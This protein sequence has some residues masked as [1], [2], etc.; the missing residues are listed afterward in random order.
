MLYVGID[1]GTSAVKLVLMNEIGQVLSSVSE[2]YKLSFPHDGW[3]EQN[4]EDWFEMTIKGL[5]ELLSK[6]EMHDVRAI[7]I[8]GQMH[9]LVTL[10]ANDRVIRPAILWNDG[11]SQEET[12]KLNEEFG[13]DN[14]VRE[15]GNIAFAGFMAP[16]ILWMKHH[17]P[18]L[19][20]RINKIMLPKD[21]LVYRMTGEFT[22]DASDAAGMLLMNVEHRKYSQ[23]MLELCGINENMLPKIYESYE[24]VGRLM[25]EIKNLIGFD[26]NQSIIMAAGAG[27]NAA[28]AVGTGV[29]S[30][31]KGI[32]AE[33]SCNCNISLGTSGTI[34]VANK[35]YVDVPGHGLHSFAHSDGSYA[36]LGCMLSAASCNKWWMDNILNCSDYKLEQSKINEA[37][38]GENSVFFLPYLIGERCPHNDP[39][40]RGGFFGLSLD[41]TRADITQAIL[42][43][44]CFGIRDS[45]ELAK[46]AGATI[47]MSRICG[48]GAKSEL[49]KRMMASVLRISLQRVECEEGPGFGGAI[50]AAVADGLYSSVDEAVS[51]VVRVSEIT[52]VDEE[53]AAKYEERYQKYRELYPA[54]RDLYN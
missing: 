17:E 16:K 7:G 13:V 3:S 34:F 23:K 52:S 28:A 19:F 33:D 15:T 18:E 21:Y 39:R 38:L 46:A 35:D 24:V 41:T 22:T 26:S 49:W 31:T 11:R 10:D 27:D 8:A 4:P 42:E 45:I 44:V 53:L 43:G 20:A 30:G 54:V 25:P 50:L 2:E 12:R 6:E 37:R 40:V 48:G 36:F 29:I 9:G 47:N 32:E 1:L 51:K 14:L 5:K